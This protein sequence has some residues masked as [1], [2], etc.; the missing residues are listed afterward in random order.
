MGRGVCVQS[1]Q[2]SQAATFA[3]FST[4][5]NVGCG[6]SVLG[7]KPLFISDM[8]HHRVALKADDEIGGLA[9]VGDA[10]A[11]TRIEAPPTMPLFSRRLWNAARSFFE[12][13]H[14]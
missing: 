2:P 9:V 12:F 4:A 1:S 5:S 10:D 6:E 7:N 11:V 8:H 14:P 13:L 3:S